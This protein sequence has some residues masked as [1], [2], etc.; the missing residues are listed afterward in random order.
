MGSRDL[1]LTL[2]VNSELRK[3]EVATIVEEHGLF[4]QIDIDS[5]KAENIVELT[6]I[7]EKPSTQTVEK[8]PNR[9]DP[10]SCGSGKKFKKCCGC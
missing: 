2:L 4:A 5:A 6:T 9:N 7:L 10:C 1:P 3:K 8:T